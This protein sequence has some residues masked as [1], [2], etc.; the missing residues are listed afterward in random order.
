MNRALNLPF[1]VILMGIGALAMF[2][3]FIHAFIVRD[4]LTA[5]SFFYSGMVFSFLTTLIGFATYNTRD[6][7]IA[8]SHLLA[9]PVTFVA[10][11]LMLAVPF[12]EAVR[13]TT[14]LNAYFEMVSSLTTTGATLFDN[15]ERLAPSVHLWRVLVGWLGGLFIWV[16]AIAI[17]SP[18]NLGGFEVISPERAGRGA[19]PVEDSVRR[20]DPRERLMRFGLQLAPIYTGL[21]SILWL[22]LI[23]SGEDP[24]VAVCHAM[25]TLATS[26]ISPVGGLDGSNAFMSG[27][28][29]IFAF[30]IFAV[31][32]Q[33]FNPDLG[34]K[35]W[36]RPGQDA[37][38]TMAVICVI[39]V[40]LFLFL[41]HWLGAYDVD[42]QQNLGRAF[43]SLWGSVFSVLSFLTTTGFISSDWA[44]AREWSGLQTPGLILL[45]LALTGGG[46]ATTAGG[47]KL[48]RVYA[49]YK[50][51]VRE[52]EK[53]VHPHSVGG[54][55]AYARHIRRQGAAVAW[56]FFMLF[57]LNIAVVMSALSL[58]GLT[59][60]EV[61]IL[62]V[63]ALSTTGPLAQVAGEVPISY[64]ELGAA[65]KLI[66]SAAMVL[67]RLETLAI[68]ALFNPE[69]W[70][71]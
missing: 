10:L 47:V 6:R 57:A 50:H 26:G 23:L 1:L 44:Q 14:F 27:E 17:L 67:G 30:F 53:L 28:L 22:M 45:G 24:F 2:L 4:W 37:E 8:R 16:T 62:S 60:E 15:P 19:R 18:M 36:W 35:V 11:P 46:V 61:T 31:T 40:P 54:S 3:P 66:L 70:R 63:S 9:L 21:T 64:S 55:G 25:S 20:T 65:G 56:V 32:R 59:F 7:N 41:R 42:D 39:V 5:R 71:H 51:G 33:S 69:F 52:M 12:Q 29:F 43:A 34:S 58:T 38:V 49:L 68:I 13:N 48:L